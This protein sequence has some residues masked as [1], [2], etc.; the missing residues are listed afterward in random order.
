MGQDTW[1]IVQSKYNSS[2]NSKY[3]TI[4]TLANGYR[5]LRGNIE[6]SKIGNRGN[7]IAGIFDKSDA[8]V[9]EIVNCQDPLPLN[10]YIE[11]EPLDFERCNILDFSR[12]LNMKEGVLYLKARLKTPKGRIVALTSERCVSK[13]NV[14]RWGAKYTV[15]PE[16][17][18]GK[19]FIE[20]I[21]DGT[22]TNSA[23]D[24]SARAKHFSV[25]EAYDL[26]PGIALKTS[27]LEKR[28]GV[29]E[30]SVL[31]GKDEKG[32]CL[33]SRKYNVFGEKVRE[34]YEVFVDIN[35]E[36]TIYKLGCTYSS[37][38]S[39]DITAA[40]RQNM[41]SY[42]NDGFENEKSS[43]IKVM[44][45]IWD[46]IDIQIEGDNLAQIGTRFNLFQ[47]SSS[48]Y[49]DDE[50]VSIA[51][52]GLHGE[53][54]KGHVFWDTE[55]FML[56]FFIYTM[57][58]VARSILLYRYN[59]LK[60]AR[61][62]AALNG[63]KGAQFPWESADEGLEVTP[64]WGFDYDGNPIRIWTGDEEFHINSDIAFGIYEYYRA[65]LDK[66]F[67][68]NFGLEI[69]FDTATFWKSRVEYNQAEGRYEINKVIGPDEFHEHVNNNA[70]TNYLAKWNLKKALQFAKLAKKEDRITFDNLCTKLGL[71]DNDFKQWDIIQQKLYLPKGKDGKLIEEFEGYLSL[72][73]VTISEYDENG[74]P[75]WPELNGVKYNGTQLIKQPDVVM[76][77]IMMG[78]EFDIDVKLEN[79]KYYEVRTMH[80]SS[81]SPSM[82]SILGLAVGDTRNSYRYFIKTVMTDLEDNQGNTALGFHAASAGG[83]WQSAIF[84]FGGLSV[85]KD[86]ILNL[87]PWIPDGW[88]SMSFVIIWQGSRVSVKITK[89]SV[90]I[91]PNKDV[92]VKVF[93][94]EYSLSG[95]KR[96]EFLW[97]TRQ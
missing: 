17:F 31:I 81:L 24:P 64:K 66:K 22:V 2:E 89:D 16:N 1:N 91:T 42:L 3:E 18:S 13:H 76:L 43:H 49:K 38:D 19:I 96:G 69:F 60:G 44:K 4:F 40:C 54:Y 35:V 28:I 82:Y 6:F 83:S 12:T 23:W 30:S 73:D 78:E 45:K 21:I 94:R 57:P 11:D 68:I 95:G 27:T 29:I 79:Y 75:L 72:P 80:K 37:R 65:T 71:D 87:N 70:Y 62:N 34:L 39:E 53:G 86:M 97:K 61:K 10:I 26:A 46:T 15:I 7:F 32:N 20:N 67:M 58:D 77:M 74:M 50:K 9:T 33:K 8:Q 59:T 14:H 63:Y 55:T 85:D 48:A 90:A 47:L 51:A 93:G 92:K 52:K 84:G 88:K 41:L 25:K 56:P 36:Y 5:G